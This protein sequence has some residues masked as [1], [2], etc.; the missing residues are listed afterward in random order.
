MERGGEY[1]GCYPGQSDDDLLTASVCF[2][3]CSPARGPVGLAAWNEEGKKK[4]S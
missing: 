2:C 4:K 3:P 1:I